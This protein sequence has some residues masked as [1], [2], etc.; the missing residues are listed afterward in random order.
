EEM[1]DRIAELGF[2]TFSDLR[3]TISRNQLKLPDVTDPQEFVRSDPLL[4]LDRRLASALDGVYRPGEFYLRWLER[5][6]VPSFGTATGRLITRYVTLPF[7]GALLLLEGLQVMLDHVGVRL[8]TFA[9][10]SALL[11]VEGA[12]ARLPIVGLVAFLA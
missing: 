6:T 5:I 2:L 11:P 1:L 10:L 3:D 9:P 8:P 4:R 12:P 7:G